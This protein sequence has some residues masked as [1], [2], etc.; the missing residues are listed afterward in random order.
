MPVSQLGYQL[1]VKLALQN[2][3]LDS[4]DRPVL[5]EVVYALDLLG[6]PT[7]VDINMKWV[8]QQRIEAS[9]IYLTAKYEKIRDKQE[10]VAEE[11]EAASY[12]NLPDKREDDK[13][14]TLDDKKHL[15]KVEPDVAVAKDKL[16]ELKALANLLSKLSRTVF[17]RNQKLDHLGVN[18]RREIQADE[19][20]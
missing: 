18:I 20:S 10:G 17:G 9:M 3:Y 12:L 4:S 2:E 5:K 1:T 16:R 14:Y 15:V 6:D 13:R 19:N 11:V 7:L 8:A